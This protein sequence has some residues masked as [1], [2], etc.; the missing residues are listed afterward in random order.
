[1]QTKALQQTAM[2]QIALFMTGVMALFLA[3]ACLAIPSTIEKMIGMDAE[4]INIL[5]YALTAVGIGDLVVSTL[6]FRRREKK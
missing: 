5:G 6:V 2:I 1:M 3:T 4:T